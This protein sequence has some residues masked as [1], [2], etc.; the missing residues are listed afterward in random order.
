[1]A[2]SP[3]VNDLLFPFSTLIRVHTAQPH[4]EM[5]RANTRWRQLRNKHTQR[6]HMGAVAAGNVEVKER[7][8]SFVSAHIH[9]LFNDVRG[10]ERCQQRDEV[11]SDS[12]TPACSSVLQDTQ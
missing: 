1:M 11:P 9:F 4:I 12:I 10:Y 2:A 8:A 3:L 6:T 7:L 5:T